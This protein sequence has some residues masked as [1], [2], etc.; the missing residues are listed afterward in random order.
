MAKTKGVVVVDVNRC[1]GCELCIVTCP[2]EVL[3]NK[4]AMVN[5]KGYH[6]VY[7]EHPDDC[8]GCTN[9]AIVCPDG[10]LT[11]YR[12]KQTLKKTIS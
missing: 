5:S 2:H 6:Y 12:K 8:T 7:M 4:A 3:A 1:K 11:I 9:C 10:V